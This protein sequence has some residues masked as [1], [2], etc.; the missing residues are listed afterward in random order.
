MTIKQFIYFE[1]MRKTVIEMKND[2]GTP[3]QIQ[4]TGTNIS[5][6]VFAQVWLGEVIEGHQFIRSLEKETEKWAFSLA[7]LN[8]P[9]HAPSNIRT[10][11]PEFKLALCRASTRRALQKILWISEVKK[12]VWIGYSLGF[13]SIFQA[14]STMDK[15][16]KIKGILAKSGIH[17]YERILLR[18]LGKYGYPQNKPQAWAQLFKEFQMDETSW[19]WQMPVLPD[20]PIPMHRNFL[21][22]ARNLKEQSWCPYDLECWH[23]TYD[24]WSTP[25]DITTLSPRK[26]HTFELWHSL[27]PNR[28]INRAIF[29]AAE[30][31][32]TED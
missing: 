27:R 5:N 20:N 16:P 26:I 1:G 19:I 32:F 11:S 12:V 30:R 28:D 6:L 18:F 31:M 2:S 15:D 23:G 4:I 29:A 21:R 7:T 14:L 13:W 22:W 9:L 17:S 3:S 10:D 8:H 25:E 24:H